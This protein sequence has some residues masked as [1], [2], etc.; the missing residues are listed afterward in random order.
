MKKRLLSLFLALC[1]VLGMLPAAAIASPAFPFTVTVGGKEMTEISEGT[2]AFSD[3]TGSVCDVTCYTVQVPA[4]AVEAT[5]TFEEEKQWSYYDS[6]G[7][8][9]G[10]GETSWTAATEHT[11]AV[12]DSNGDGELDGIS[13]QIPND[14]STEFYILF[15]YAPESGGGAEPETPFLSI[16]IGDV[17]LDADSIVYKGIFEL[18]D[19]AVDEQQGTDDYYDYVHY[20]P[21]YHVTVPCGT[22][23]VYVT[24]SG[25]TNILNDG[26]NAYGYQTDLEVDAVTSATVR[27]MTLKDSYTQNEDGTQTVETPVTGYT[28]DD[29]G[30]GHALTLEQDGGSYEAICL[31]AFVEEHT[32]NEADVCVRCGAAGPGYTAPGGAEVPEGAPFTALTTDAGDATAFEDRGTVDYTGWST[33]YGV[34]YYHVTIP[35]NA[36][37]VYVTHPFSEDPFCDA[38]YG[39]AYGYAAETGGWTGSGTSFAFEETEDGYIITL[40]LSVMVD[41][42]GDWS[43]DSE[44]SFVAD[45]DGYVGYAAAVERNDFSPICF[46]T[47]ELAAAEPGDHTHDYG[48]GTVTTEPGCETRGEMTFTC[49]CGD[50]YTEEISPTGHDYDGGV[51]AKAPTCTEDGEMRFTCRNDASHTRTEKLSRL[52]H[53]YGEGILDPEPTCTEAGVRTYT[54]SRCTEDTE[55]HTKTETVAATGHDYQ[56]GQC[57]NCGDACPMQDENGVF[58]IGTYEELLW[59]AG[60]VNGGSTAISGALTGDITLAEDWPGIG[61]SGNPFAGD[62]DGRNHTVTLSGGTWGLFAYTMGTHKDHSLADA[63]VIENL[64][65]EGSVKN[66]ALIQRAGYTHVKNVINRADITG[67]NS[68]VGGI[69]GTVIG[70]NKYG[71]TYSDIRIQNCGNEG[72]ILGG[73]KTGGILGYTQTGTHLDGCY[74]TGSISGDTSVGGLVGYMQG[75]SKNCSIQNSYNRGAVQ[76]GSE[77]AGIVGTQYNG[78]TVKNCYNAGKTA[79]AIAGRVYNKTAAAENVYYRTDLSAYGE[80]EYYI[81]S[82]GGNSGFN[83]TVRGVGKGTAEMGGADFAA[84]LGDAFKESCGGPVL[85]WQEAKEHNLTDGICYDCKA[86]HTEKAEYNV[87]KSTGDG[88]EIQGDTVVKE[89][90]GYTF[91]V[92]IQDGYYATDSFSV[93]ANGTALTATDGI[94]TVENITGHFYV[95]VSGVKELEGVLPVTLPGAGQGYRVT[96]CEGYG[97]TVVR[98]DDFKFT[99]SFAD[100][101]QAGPDFA[102]KVN[103]VPVTSDE[104]GVYTV[105]AVSAKL[106][107][108]VEGVD[109]IVS[110]NTVTVKVDITRGQEEFL[111]AEDSGELMLDKEI[112]IAYFDLALYGLEKYYYNPYCYV[113]AEGNINSQQRSG[114]RETAYDVV[115]SMHA[116][117]YITEIYYLGIDPED[118]GTGFSDTVDTDEDGISDF[119]EAVN[120][121]QGVGSSFMNLWGLGS[122]LNYHLNYAYPTAYPKW[123]STSDQQPLKDGDVLSIHLITGSASGSAFGFFTVNDGDGIYDGTEQKD[124]ASVEQGGQLRLSLYWGAQ[125]KDYTTDFVNGGVKSVYWVEQGDEEAAVTRWNRDSFG[126]MTPDAL[127]TDENGVITIDTTGLA[128]GTY[129]LAVAGEF[130]EG[131]GQAGSDGYVSRGS[132]A[133]PAYF[134]LTVLEAEQPEAV[135]GD[136]NCDEEI[137]IR[138]A[139]LVVSHFYGNAEFTEE[140]AAAADVNGDGEIDVRDA[141]LIV[142]YYYG[143]ID[144]LPVEG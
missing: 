51:Q 103:G 129:Y 47:F 14:F 126:G 50:S 32:F 108:T 125:G 45:E 100:G 68:N 20:V 119:D 24:Y 137:D 88:Y 94:Y 57:A 13:V 133:G 62:F 12:Q 58:L 40:P 76:G 95:T 7:N 122:N 6:T 31:F 70:S 92:V 85:T 111:Y 93:Y 61:S 110:G 106:T 91:R 81:G 33:Y 127:V 96:P 63:V 136:V 121:S 66:S 11:V 144:K 104:N 82:S 46:F 117:I 141:N 105:E 41:T 67:G 23:S 39:S 56:D 17:E 38:S 1:M 131:S 124:S 36:T 113:D 53:S 128:P 138:D 134:K 87:I 3:W 60:Q 142:S 54:C 77:A 115:T 130:V 74:N 19:Y 86:G 16:R 80:P 42:D 10:E 101:F 132:E 43:A 99:V 140:Q 27:G 30:N 22:A 114:N 37:E 98:G 64:I 2:V 55:G 107:V 48:E 69:V 15:V 4:G 65:L 118:A 72:D 8:Y 73:S 52:G 89:G 35:A 143:N 59:F 29:E 116:F 26:T 112:E 90:S 139:N 44:G 83:T 78:V 84:L 34:P 109:I 71:Q 25:D 5:L 49:S 120:W 28:F 79:Y 75:S 18:G 9:I 102:V 123:G 135:Y 97:T 21:Y